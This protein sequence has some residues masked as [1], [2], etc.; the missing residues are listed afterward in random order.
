[1]PGEHEASERLATVILDQRDRHTELIVADDESGIPPDELPRVFERFFRG[2]RDSA[3]GSGIE[4]SPSPPSWSRRAA[5]RSRSRAC[6]ATAAVFW[7][8]CPASGP[9][10]YQ[11]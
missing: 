6:P 10:R 1:L 2:S 4:G 9:D 8:A 11:G 7:C 5:M 3:A